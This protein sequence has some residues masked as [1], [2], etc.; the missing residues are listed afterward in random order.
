MYDLINLYKQYDS[1]IPISVLK[2]KDM[3]P[4]FE[5]GLKKCIIMVFLY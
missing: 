4:N 3:Y 5:V 1:K 2:L